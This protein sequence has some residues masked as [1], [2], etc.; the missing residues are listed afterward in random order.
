MF[1]MSVSGF[2]DSIIEGLD[3]AAEDLEAVSKFLDTAGTQLT[4]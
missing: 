1:R 2:R 4:S 3:G